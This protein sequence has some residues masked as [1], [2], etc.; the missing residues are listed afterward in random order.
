LKQI[1]IFTA[2]RWE[3]RAVRRAMTVEA[4]RRIAARIC[5][6]GSRAGHRLF[7]LQTGVGPAHAAAACREVLDAQPLDLVIS[8][9]FACALTPARIGDLLI[10]TDIIAWGG[11]M[12]PPNA[13]R[14]LACEPVAGAAA[15]EAG[16]AVGL[17]T[18][19]GRIVS[20]PRVLWRA[21]DKRRVAEATAAIAADMESAA[22][23]AAAAER[24]I[25]VAV[26]R[27]VSDVLDEDLPLDFNLFLEEP[28]RVPQ[29]VAG[30]VR[31]KVL[32]G[33]LRL[34]MQG[35]LASAHLTQC[36]ARFLDGLD[37]RTAPAARATVARG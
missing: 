1:G 26:I 12:D 2:T 6:V 23:G 22:L 29:A 35:R 28:R 9:G 33:L 13:Q 20:V 24:G 7:V 14:S 21:E 18:C 19:A 31:P 36:V 16:R 3:Q 8:A 37:R 11:R 25:G 27:T 5:L 15:I 4:R 34:G 30:L 32:A 17:T 10:G